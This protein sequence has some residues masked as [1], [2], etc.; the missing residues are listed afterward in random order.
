MAMQ[1]GMTINGVDIN[2]AYIKVRHI[3]G[4]K[5]NM[6]AS[7]EVYCNKAVADECMTTNIGWLSV[8]NFNFTPNL[9]SQFNV[10]AQAYQYLMTLD[11]FKDAVEV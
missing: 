9:N 7:V 4:N 6:V 10:I 2:N 5:T 1:M 8:W 11:M 3:Q